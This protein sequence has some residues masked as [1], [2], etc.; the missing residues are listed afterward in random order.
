MQYI[1]AYCSL[2]Y[3]DTVTRKSHIDFV[4]PETTTSAHTQIDVLDLIANGLIV[5]ADGASEQIEKLAII[6]PYVKHLI[7]N[8]RISS[9]LDVF[10]ELKNGN[11]KWQE[12]NNDIRLYLLSDLWN[13][14]KGQLQNE[15][16]NLFLSPSDDHKCLF[17]EE[18]EYFRKGE[19][20][21]WEFAKKLFYP[22]HSLI[23]ADPYLFKDNMAY[24]QS[25]IKEVLPTGLK[26]TYH[27]TLVG[28]IKK[29]NM[30]DKHVANAVDTL[31]QLLNKAGIKNKL[32][33][34]IYDRDDFH[35]RYLISNNCCVFSGSGMDIINNRTNKSQKEGSW[36]AF[37]PYKRVNING[38][39][40]V[41]FYNILCQKLEV[42]NNWIL[43]SSNNLMQTESE[44]PLFHLG[45][46][47]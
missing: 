13:G 45:R 23:I 5:K 39:D 14:I 35:D 37:K 41:F 32:E 31:Q 27:L 47:G 2:S 16:G 9:N 19:E 3:L 24:C 29:Q 25:F 22:H 11:Y 8:F 46:N 1:P 42:L 21:T 4:N 18:I 34:F 20:K 40:G 36:I 30:T 38:K 7:K 15:S 26:S 28:S 33:Y 17:M 10:D 12:Q 43:N 6:N 44:N